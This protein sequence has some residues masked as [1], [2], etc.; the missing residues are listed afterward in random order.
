MHV[1]NVDGVDFQALQAG[2]ARFHQVMARR[3]QV[4]GAFVFAHAESGF[5]GKSTPDCVLPLMAWPRISFGDAIG[6]DI[7]GVK[8]VYAGFEADVPP[9]A[10]ASRNVAA[11][12]TPL[13]KFGAAAKCAGLRKLSTGTFKP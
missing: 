9:V 4:V 13:K 12:P 1:V 2:L 3:S 6:I 11:A 7:G 8:E 5:G 10:F